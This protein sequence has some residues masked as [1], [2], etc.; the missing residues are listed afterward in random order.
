MRLLVVILTASTG[1]LWAQRTASP[2]PCRDLPPAVRKAADAFQP[3]PGTEPECEKISD[4][5]RTLYNVKIITAESRMREVVFQEEGTLEEVQDEGNLATIPAPARATIQKAVAQRR[6]A[7]RKVDVIR[8]GSTI[9][10]EGEFRVGEAKENIIVDA[11]GH[12]VWR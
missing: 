3:K 12:L 6:G 7:L 10:Y 1:C 4:K 9:L 5:G 2:L 11:R 8:R